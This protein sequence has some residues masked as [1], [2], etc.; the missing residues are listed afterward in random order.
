MNIEVP[1]KLSAKEKKAIK[2][3]AEEFTPDSYPRKKEFDNLKLG[4]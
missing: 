3:M 1:T 2:N 4:S